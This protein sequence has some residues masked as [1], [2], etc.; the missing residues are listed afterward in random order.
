MAVLS[1]AI[2]SVPTDVIDTHYCKTCAA[3]ASGVT[4][5]P[6]TTPWPRFATPRR[7][8]AAT[9]D[10]TTPHEHPGGSRHAAQP[11]TWTASVLPQPVN[12]TIL[13]PQ[14]P[15]DVT[16]RRHPPGDHRRAVA[17]D[18][19]STSLHTVTA[20]GVC[21]ILGDDEADGTRKMH[22]ATTSRA[23]F[24]FRH[25][26]R[27]TCSALLV[28]A[29]AILVVHL[30]GA[31]ADKRAARAAGMSAPP[32]TQ[33]V[34]AAMPGHHADDAPCALDDGISEAAMPHSQ[35]SVKHGSCGYLCSRQGGHGV[36]S[37][38]VCRFRL[39]TDPLV[40]REL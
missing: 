29:T 36:A 7:A 25:C 17:I 6:R 15:R 35:H 2:V 18:E 19:Q 11:S 9:P 23:C 24:A 3:T 40:P 33:A 31:H 12:T 28:V 37:H 8:C 39:N 30:L 32:S 21:I 38:L 1:A 16:I 14:A 27:G 13:P 22:E 20:T 5:T 4:A 10:R 34:A 26:S